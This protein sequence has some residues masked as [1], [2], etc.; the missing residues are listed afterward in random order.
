MYPIARRLLRYSLSGG[1]AAVCDIGGFQLLCWI[2]V[3]TVPAAACSFVAATLV[4]FLLTSKWVFA[5]RS[6]PRRYVHFLSASLIGLFANV[7]LSSAGVLW[8]G[9]PAVTAKAIAIGVTF[10]LNFWIN[11]EIVFREGAR[12]R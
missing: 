10:L 1:A 2:P 9:L 4:N 11:H 6:T 5:S 12:P 3:P 8:L 7:L